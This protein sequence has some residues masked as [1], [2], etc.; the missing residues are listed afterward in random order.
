MQVVEGLQ[1]FDSIQINTDLNL[2]LG[3]PRE[4]GS[5]NIRMLIV[6]HGLF[7]WSTMAAQYYCIGNISS[8]FQ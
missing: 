2:T 4:V 8:T 6:T 5:V 3:L 7:P 1:N